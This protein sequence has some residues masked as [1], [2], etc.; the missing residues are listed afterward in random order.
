MNDR[1]RRHINALR[2]SSRGE[3]DNECAARYGTSRAGFVR[4][5]V[6]LPCFP[7]AGWDQLATF[8]SCKYRRLRAPATKFSSLTNH[9]TYRTYVWSG[10]LAEWRA[11]TS[12]IAR[13]RIRD[14]REQQICLILI[15]TT[16]P[17]AVEGAHSES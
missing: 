4:Y 3:A 1:V 11:S 6:Y 7:E 12:I 8:H 17:D 16:G 14:E 15:D 10:P 13:G 2:C 9:R 5:L